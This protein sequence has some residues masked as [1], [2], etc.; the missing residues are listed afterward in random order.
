MMGGF[1]VT[2]TVFNLPGVGKLIVSTALA[3]DYPVM[4]NLFLYVVLMTM[5][6]NLLVD[7]SYGLLDPRIRQG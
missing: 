7:L 5:I 2:E 1:V 3:R 4:Q 6:V